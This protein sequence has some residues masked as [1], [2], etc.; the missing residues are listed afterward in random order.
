MSQ[1]AEVINQRNAESKINVPVVWSDHSSK[2]KKQ[3]I[4]GAEYCRRNNLNLMAWY[5]YTRRV[6]LQSQK[7]KAENKKAERF[8]FT[9]AQVV[10]AAGTDLLSTVKVCLKNHVVIECALRDVKHVYR[11]LFKEGIL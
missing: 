2:M 4:S 8:S 9:K 7:G 10:E 1:N 5:A 11:E 6:R 3:G